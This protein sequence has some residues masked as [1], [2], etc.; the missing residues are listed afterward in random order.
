MT[1]RSFTSKIMI[2][3]FALVGGIFDAQLHILKKL[4]IPQ[5]L[6]IAPQGLFVIGVAFAAE[7]AR[8]QGVTADSPVAEKFDAL[9][10]G[11]LRWRLVLL[12]AAERSC[13]DF[14]W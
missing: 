2:L 5:R 7:D 8:F 11:R 14:P 10:D 9:D 1:G 3:A 4:G 13:G 6:K 12:A